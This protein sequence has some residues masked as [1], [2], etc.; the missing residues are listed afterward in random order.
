VKRL[1]CL[2]A[3]MSIVLGASLAAGAVSIDGDVSYL[4]GLGNQKAA[5]FAGHAMVEV[6]S[7]VL[8]D[9]SFSAVT[10]KG[11]GA[12]PSEQLFTLGGLYRVASEDDLQVFVGGGFAMLTRPEVDKGQGIYGKFGFKLIPMEK[13]TLIADVAY[14]P[15][16]KVG[17]VTSNLTTARATISYDVM[18]N[19]AVQGTF[20]HYRSG[21]V[22][23]GILIGGGVSVTF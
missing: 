1:V 23:S 2:F 11:D 21:D 6:M 20:K 5:G 19:V 22:N 16:Y 12:G 9:G 7:Q 10:P 8:A 17:D 18:E 13:L 4:F 3:V 15:K 14:A